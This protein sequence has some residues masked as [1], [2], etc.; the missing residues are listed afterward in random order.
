[1]EGDA[2]E[3][4]VAEFTGAVAIEEGKIGTVID[5]GTTLAY[6]PEEAYNQ[7]D[8]AIAAAIPSSVHIVTLKGNRCY[9]TTNSVAVFPQASFNFADGASLVLR[10]QD[11]LIKGNAVNL[12]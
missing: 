11:Y 8:D 9:S 10:P 6:L 1:M 5:S 7:F 4:E 3:E 12:Y 2:S